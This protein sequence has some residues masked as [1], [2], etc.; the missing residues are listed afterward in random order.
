MTNKKKIIS[1]I[2]ASAALVTT[3]SVALAVTSTNEESRT[4]NLSGYS[5][6]MSGPAVYGERSSSE[7]PFWQQRNAALADLKSK[8]DEME[9]NY[10]TVAKGLKDVAILVT[11][12]PASLYEEFKKMNN[13]VNYNYRVFENRTLVWENLI[14]HSWSPK[15]LKGVEAYINAEYINYSMDFKWQTRNILPRTKEIK[16]Q[17]HRSHPG[18]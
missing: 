13:L 12:M 8:T 15:N 6:K 10:I 7:Q 1:F 17:Y 4:N 9:Q 18:K 16:F 3:A 14:Q 11:D 5:A 2:G